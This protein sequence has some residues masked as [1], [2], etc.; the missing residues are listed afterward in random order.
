LLNLPKS[1]TNYSLNLPLST[2]T[3]GN[4]SWGSTKVSHVRSI[5]NDLIT[6]RIRFLWQITLVLPFC[7]YRAYSRYYL[8]VI[9][10]PLLSYIWRLKSRRSQKRAGKEF[11]VSSCF[12][13][14]LPTY[15]IIEKLLSVCSS[16]VPILLYITTELSNKT[17]INSLQSLS[18]VPSSDP[19]P[20]ESSTMTFRPLS[21]RSLVDS[22]IPLLQ[23]LIWLLIGNISSSPRIWFN[24]KLFPVLDFPAIAN[25]A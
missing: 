15:M 19:K 3:D 6:L 14:I 7:Y 20:S 4:Y 2:P 1:S 9:G 5:N 11:Y 23:L 17:N 12:S 22:M 25:T 18:S 24:R 13:N 16:M 8:G 21:W 10:D